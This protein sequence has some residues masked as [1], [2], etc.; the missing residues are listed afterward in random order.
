MIPRS[1][2]DYGSLGFSTAP[3]V[4]NIDPSDPVKGTGGLTIDMEKLDA[5]TM[6]AAAAQSNGDPA[7]AWDFVAQGRATPPVP[8]PVNL[9]GN[10]GDSQ[11][12]GTAMHPQH[13]AHGHS[14]SQP[15]VNQS[16]KPPEGTRPASPPQ[17]ISEAQASSPGYPH[18]SQPSP[19]VNFNTQPV[20]PPQAAVPQPESHTQAMLQQMMQMMHEIASR[21]AGPPTQLPLPSPPAMPPAQPADT[22]SLVDQVNKAR[23]EKDR[24]KAEIL[25]AIR[26][27]F[28][29]GTEGDPDPETSDASEPLLAVPEDTGLSFLTSPPSKPG[30]VV[31]FDLGQLGGSHLKRYH[32]VASRDIWI[33][34]IY[35]SR[36]EGDQFI[37][38]AT[39]EGQPPI[40]IS[41]PDH[42]NKKLKAQVP[43]SCHQ[44]IGCM[45]IIN[46]IIVS[47]SQD[48]DAAAAGSQTFQSPVEAH[49]MLQE[50]NAYVPG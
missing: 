35:D 44:R 21:P 42:G 34:L 33:S 39:D 9:Q 45:D 18:T 38:P 26:D 20:Y 11:M 22:E 6:K 24:M 40:T 36:Y 28:F 17:S 41:F 19:P 46:L 48:S 31:I 30:V 25:E 7:T 12:V 1:K 4:L 16:V 49:Q 2:K 8:Q 27:E 37:P 5:D 13:A 32:H 43:E 47:S 14:S 3:G 10:S 15:I 23:A 50:A 29:T